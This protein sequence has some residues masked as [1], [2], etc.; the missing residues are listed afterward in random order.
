MV[1]DHPKKG[2]KWWFSVLMGHRVWVSWVMAGGIM[3]RNGGNG[4]EWEKMGGNGGKRLKM[5]C[6]WTAE[7]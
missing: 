6:S 5:C 3:G 4:R 7:W 1:I 2:G